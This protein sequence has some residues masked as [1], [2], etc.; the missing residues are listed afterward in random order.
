MSKR[1][2]EITM[3]AITIAALT[4]GLILGTRREAN[5]FEQRRAQIEISTSDLIDA[6]ARQAQKN[7]PTTVCVNDTMNIPTVKRLPDEVIAGALLY[8]WTQRELYAGTNT[9]WIRMD[10]TSYQVR[11][12]R[13]HE[14]TATE[15]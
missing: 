9:Q 2:F 3:L 11:R 5:D 13:C 8:Q 6:L 7:Q 10:R 15:Q 14:T 4:A 1:R 12:G